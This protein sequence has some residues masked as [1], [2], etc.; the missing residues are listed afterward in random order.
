M[1][2][3]HTILLLFML[4]HL[5]PAATAQDD[6]K[7]KDAERLVQIKPLEA[8]YD[9]V[10]KKH[11]VFFAITL[12][13]D[14]RINASIGMYS[15][16]AVAVNDSDLIQ[17]CNATGLTYSTFL[18]VIA[19]MKKAECFEVG[20]SGLGTD[21]YEIQIGYKLRL[22]GKRLTYMFPHGSI[23]ME[24]ARKNT[25]YEWVTDHIYREKYKQR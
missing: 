2:M 1:K 4:L 15:F 7:K 5:L 12:S 6:L 19:Q 10:L 13:E 3:K 22:G 17:R 16:N 21:R 23:A 20:N 9:S 11:N 18:E 8:F 24:R 25:S 14:E